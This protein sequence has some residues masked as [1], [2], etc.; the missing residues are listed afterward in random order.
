RGAA[1]ARL[2]W[3]RLGGDRRASGAG[4]AGAAPPPPAPKGGTDGGVHRAL[5]TVLQPDPPLQRLWAARP[6]GAVWLLEGRPPAG[7]S[8][9]GTTVRRGATPAAGP[10]VS[11]SGGPGSPAGP[12]LT[13]GPR[14]RMTAGGAE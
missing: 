12:P 13:R 9:G 6:F 1:T 3:G 5:G 4:G 7:V 10:R 2:L 11:G 14:P 8:G